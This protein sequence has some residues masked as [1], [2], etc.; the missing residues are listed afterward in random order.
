[1]SF[2]TRNK[3][4]VSMGQEEHEPLLD[5]IAEAGEISPPFSDEISDESSEADQQHSFTANA[6]ASTQK[7]KYLPGIDEDGH[8]S[9]HTNDPA[10]G[11]QK[12]EGNSHGNGHRARSESH[13][14]SRGSRR[15]RSSS[16]S[17][18]NRGVGAG[19][20]GGGSGNGNGFSGLMAPEGYKDPEIVNRAADRKVLPRLTG[21]CTAGRYVMK[22]LTR[23]F[24][25]SARTSPHHQAPKV[26]DDC[27]YIEYGERIQG[28]ANTPTS[29][30]VVPTASTAGTGTGTGTGTGSRFRPV[31]AGWYERVDEEGKTVR[32]GGWRTRDVYIF[33]YG[34]I[35]LWGFSSTD[36]KRILRELAPFELE[37]LASG[38]VE[39]EEM[40]Y[41]VTYDERPRIFDDFIAVDPVGA[42]NYRYK[43]SISHA[44]AQSV[45]MSLYEE[46]ID[47]TIGLMQDIPG[48]VAMSGKVSMSRRQIMMSIGELFILR[49]NINL[50]GSIIDSPEL[51]WSEPEL[52][53][54]YKLVRGYME[55]G[56]R[57]GVLNQRLEVISDLLQMLKEQ[58]GHVHEEYLEFIVIIL[59]AV[60]IVVAVINI[61]VDMIAENMRT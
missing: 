9:G 14:S 19:M 41:F 6:A 52:E 50:H 17:S 11:L 49:I 45:K 4:G 58:L 55:I 54:A 27:I 33:E 36:E 18:S 51:V 8:R 13:G 20:G 43:L 1:M 21:Y 60:E 5:Q 35:V 3:K 40:N 42:A 12:Y 57:V 38:D 56:P 37:K 53:P 39:I 34:V 44:L 26:L 47:H 29:T 32:I 16:S 10:D 61:V 22:D 24:M 23:Y 48:E 46:L 31:G 28:R 30:T 59:I 25:N 15:A 2:R 7:P